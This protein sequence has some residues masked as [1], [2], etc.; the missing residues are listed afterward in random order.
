[1]KQLALLLI[2]VGGCAAER[3]QMTQQEWLQ[4]YKPE[5][6][7]QA[8]A[9]AILQTELIRAEAE[10]ESLAVMDKFKIACAIG[11]GVSIVAIGIGLWLKIGFISVIGGVGVLACL[12]GF[13]LAYAGSELTKYV[14][15]GGLILGTSGGA[16]TV[17][18]VGRVI[19]EL[20]SQIEFI[21]TKE[22]TVEKLLKGKE[23]PRQSATTKAVVKARRKKL[24]LQS[25][26]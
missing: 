6:E 16:C 12:S 18:L 13:G 9:M 17:Y 19:K 22:P 5:T 24:F 4:R 20:I 1:M 23:I 11:V 2:F 3:L 15:W 8:K 21:K 26:D 10:K 25:E 14:A 7:K